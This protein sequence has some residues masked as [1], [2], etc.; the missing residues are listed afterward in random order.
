MNLAVKKLA[1]I[2]LGCL[3]VAVSLGTHG[4]SQIVGGWRAEAI[5]SSPSETIRLLNKE[6]QMVTTVSK[7]RIARLVDTQSRI[8]KSAGLST[9]LFVVQFQDNRP[10]AFASRKDGRN[11]VGI[12]PAMLELLGDDFDAYAAIFGHELAHIVKQHGADRA[13]RKGVLQGLGLILGIVI[14]A[15]TGVNPGGLIDLG[16]D[17]LNKTFTRDEE[18]EADKLGIDYMVSAGFDP[19]G[20]IRLHQ[21]LMTAARTAQIP[22]LSTHPSSEERIANVREMIASLPPS[23]RPTAQLQTWL[24]APSTIDTTNPTPLPNSPPFT[25]GPPGPEWKPSVPDDYP[26]KAPTLTTPTTTA[27]AEPLQGDST[28]NWQRYTFHGGSYLEFDLDSVREV[29]EDVRSVAVRMRLSAVTA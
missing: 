24:P 18:R 29:S 9:E 27:M 28:R 17:I 8:Q 19:Q 16:T 15:R 22:F 3:L 2:A 7:S 14:G 21:R 6:K 20:A 12:T 5:A 10:N 23:G 4:A 26:W 11:I 25:P 13:A 1:S